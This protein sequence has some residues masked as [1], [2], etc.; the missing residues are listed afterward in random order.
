VLLVGVFFYLVSGAFIDVRLAASIGQNI[1]GLH[2]ITERVQPLGLDISN[3]RQISVSSGRYDFFTQIENLNDE[4]YATFDYAYVYNGG[5]TELYSGFVQPNES[6]FLPALN[7]E[8]ESRPNNVQLKLDNFVWH[9]VDKH[10]ISDTAQFISER[11]NIT[12]DQATYTKDIVVGDEQLGRSLLTLTNHS[13]YAY[14]NPEFLIKLQR[15]DKSLVS[16]TKMS[17]PEFQSNQTRTVEVRWFGQVPPSGTISVE[18]MIFYFDDRVYMNP[19]DE[20]GLDVR[21]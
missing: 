1:S 17:I 10:K 13:A 18:P 16:L 12:V 9:R 14:W 2:Q 4:W 8:T 19:D 7:L 11:S 3:T 6:R 15:A 20:T 21:R 5:T